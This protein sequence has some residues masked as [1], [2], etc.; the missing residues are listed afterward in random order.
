M[1]KKEFFISTSIFV[2]IFVFLIIASV[3]GIGA[4]RYH[5]GKYDKSNTFFVSG[6]YYY[7]PSA[8]VGS[9]GGPNVQ[10]GGI[11]AGK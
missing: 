5:D 8:R 3:M 9:V 11:H 6:H 1:S 2:L 7:S 10:G 4:P